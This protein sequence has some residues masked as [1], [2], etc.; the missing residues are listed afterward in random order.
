[1]PIS[2]IGKIHPRYLWNHFLAGNFLELET[3]PFRYGSSSQFKGQRMASSEAIDAV[4]IFL[5][6]AEMHE[7]LSGFLLVKRI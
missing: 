5:A 2:N 4:N 3:G 6:N 1:M 7:K